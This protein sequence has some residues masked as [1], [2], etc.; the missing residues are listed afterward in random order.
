MA[1]FGI[2]VKDISICSLWEVARNPVSFFRIS[3]CRLMHTPTATGQMKI[4]PGI[5]EDVFPR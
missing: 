2:S 5:I 3:K 1:Q 4:G